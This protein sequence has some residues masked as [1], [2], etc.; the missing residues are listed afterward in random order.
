LDGCWQAGVGSYVVI[1]VQPVLSIEEDL[2]LGVISPGVRRKGT[3]CAQNEEP[4]D[5]CEK[6]RPSDGSEIEQHR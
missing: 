1:A 3:N 4:E 5:E 6:A 2:V